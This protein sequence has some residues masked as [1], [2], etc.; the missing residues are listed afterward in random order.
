M[1]IEI[2]EKHG[3][4]IVDVKEDLTLNSD[5]AE[6]RGLVAGL[7]EKG[8]T[9]VAISFTQNTFLCSRAIAVV[10]QCV[11][12]LR[13]IGGTLALIDPSGEIAASLRLV[14]ILPLL[15]VVASSD[16]LSAL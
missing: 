9:R 2:A 13:N 11:E 15:K 8:K 16:D 12:S 1:E 10:V 5:G 4:S 6:L 3:F 7:V 14:G